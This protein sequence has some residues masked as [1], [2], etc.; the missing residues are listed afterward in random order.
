MMCFAGPVCNVCVQ[1]RSWLK[2]SG[3]SVGGVL[4]TVYT[5]FHRACLTFVHAI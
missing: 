1:P 2:D 5:V 3:W 4:H